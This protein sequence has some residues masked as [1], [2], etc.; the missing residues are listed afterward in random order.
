LN[1][2]LVCYKFKVCEEWLRYGTGEIE[3]SSTTI[4]DDENM[5]LAMFRKLS[6]EMR[7]VVL[8]KVNEMLALN[9]SWAVPP[10]KNPHIERSRNALA[11]YILEPLS[12]EGDGFEEERSVG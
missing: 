2:E 1:I 11:G 6:V 10:L 9:D 12:N 7:R 3:E 5:L 8:D 4:D